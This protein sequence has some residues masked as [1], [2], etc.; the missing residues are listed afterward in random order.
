[1]LRRLPLATALVALLA[2]MALYA[3]VAAGIVRQ[4]FTDSTSSHGVLLAGAALLVVRRKW[5][6]LASLPLAPRNSGFA[7]VAL[8][9]L[10]Y[11]TG[12]LTGDVFVLRASLP[13]LLFGAVLALWGGAHAR[14]LF[15]PLALVALAIPL[16]AVLVTHLTMPLQLV[17]SHVAAGVLTVSGIPVV[18]DGN[19]LSLPNITLEVADACS[20]LRSVVSLVSVAAVCAALVPLGARRTA[21]LVAAAMPIAIVGNGLRVAA[22]GML[23]FSVGDIA[24]NGTVH[25]LTGVVA[26]LSMCAATVGLLVLT[27]KGELRWARP[28]P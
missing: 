4:W 12:T 9:L 7:V 15:A 3:P 1:M 18:R 8:A 26:F 11:L 10:V 23:A 13:V 25:D 2:A 19:L 22:T 16:P 6:A 17:A 20:G 5:P 14:E 27:R 28:N 21:L 24:V